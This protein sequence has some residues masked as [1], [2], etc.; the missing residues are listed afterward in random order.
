[1]F[2]EANNQRY[3]LDTLE[4]YPYLNM[5][6]NL[7]KNE[8]IQL[9]LGRRVE[10][11]GGAH[12]GWKVMPFPTNVYN[13]QFIFVG[14]PYLEPEYSNQYDLNYSRPIPMGFA[15]LS[16]FYHDIE[17]KI[18]WYDDDQYGELGDVLTFRNVDEALSRGISFFGMI[19]GQSLGGSYTK[20]TQRDITNPN[21]YEL[22]LIHI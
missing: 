7:A 22:S 11:P 1:M 18:E 21:D 13:E 10:R 4:V 16:F 12:G 17:N 3:D 9:G 20:T 5:T 6:Y 15:S 19:M 2:N 14:N 8:S